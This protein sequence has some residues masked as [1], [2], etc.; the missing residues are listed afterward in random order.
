MNMHSIM[1]H[2]NDTGCQS[3]TLINCKFNRDEWCITAYQFTKQLTDGAIC[4]S[5]CL[6]VCVYVCLCVCVSVCMCVCESV[7]LCVCV[8]V[9]L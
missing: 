7:C 5:V 3:K 9:C 1:Y 2:I 8:P 6:C 4:V